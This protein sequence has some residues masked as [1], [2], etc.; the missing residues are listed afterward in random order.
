MRPRIF[1][2]VAVVFGALGV[3]GL[4]LYSPNHSACSSILVQATNESLCRTAN[5]FYIIS[6]VLIAVAILTTLGQ[7]ASLT[8]TR[9]ST[10]T[11]GQSSNQK[12]CVSCGKPMAI[13]SAFCSQCGATA[14]PTISSVVVETPQDKKGP[15]ESELAVSL[16]KSEDDRSIGRRRSAWNHPVAVGLIVIALIVMSGA[17]AVAISDH[18]DA[19]VTNISTAQTTIRP[20]ALVSAN[21]P[22]SSCTTTYGISGTKPA[23]LPNYV[24]EMIPRGDAGK[25]KVFADGQGIMEL[26]GPSQWGCDASIGADGSSTLYIAPIGSNNFTGKLASGSTVEQISGSQ[27]SACVSC[28]LDQACPLFAAAA[29]ENRSDYQQGCLTSAPASESVTQLTKSVV[30]FTDPPGVHGD[31]DPS[32]GAYAAHGAMTF[33]SGQLVTSW[34]ETCLLPPSQRSLCS[35]SLDDFVSAYGSK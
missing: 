34:M 8:Q 28:G 24:T 32:G 15:S 17:V 30:E 29:Q 31:A 18:H 6:W 9:N 2:P 26:V 3:G 1:V 7:I 21:L 14:A 20:S 12:F 11:T 35:A 33:S 25:L 4:L 13:N 27:T 16:E 5:S 19:T 23:H 10:P 22:L